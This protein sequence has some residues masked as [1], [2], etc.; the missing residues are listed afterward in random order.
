VKA[1]NIDFI[2]IGLQ[3]AGG[4]ALFL[5]A[6]NV[7]G[8]TLKELAGDRMKGFLS[9]FT[10]NSVSGIATGTVATTLLDSSSVV[11]IMVLTMVNA[12]LLSS[13]ESYG[14]IMGANIGTTISSQLIAFDVAGLSPVLLVVGLLLT[15][16][17]K[18]DT[19]HQ[20]G[21]VIFGAGLIFFGLWTMDKAVEPLREYSPFFE[22]MKKLDSPVQ[23]ALLGGLVTLV[24]QSSSATVGIAIVLA[25][26]GLISTQAGIA[27]MLGAE[28]GTCSDTLL[29]VIGRS[30]EAI[31][32]GVFHLLFNIVCV[33][34]GLILIQP[35][36]GTVEWIS[37][38]AQAGRK[39]ANAHMLFNIA[40]VVI[41]AWFIPFFH[42]TLN[43]I[44]R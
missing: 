13:L 30:K 6:V 42:R 34:I 33:I 18:N 8:D 11:I 36:V 1:E 31:R 28:I 38:D 19:R 40:G 44:I 14:V 27:I 5:Y 22:W 37:G 29:A 3:L 20:V 2:Q 25:S 35:L 41:F 21:K 24:I 9:R 12:G 4:L 26:Q 16:V 10:R 7:M 43:A 17:G 32:A 39:L 23:G 15:V